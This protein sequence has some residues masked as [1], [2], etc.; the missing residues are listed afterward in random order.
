MIG[1]VK[2]ILT[3]KED[4]VFLCI[5]SPKY[6]LD[7]FAPRLGTRLKELGFNVYGTVEKPID[8]RNFLE[9]SLDVIFKHEDKTIIAVDSALSKKEES[10]GKIK[11]RPNKGVL[12]AS[13]VSPFTIEVGDSSILG[14]TSCNLDNVINKKQEYVNIDEMVEKILN[15]IVKNTK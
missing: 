14:F 9:E 13:A 12:P 15:E 8:G 10:V 3:T 11:I 1:N 4:M 7:S 2:N 5:G 6:P